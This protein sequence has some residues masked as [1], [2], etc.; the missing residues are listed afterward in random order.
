MADG[1]HRDYA[2][3]SFKNDFEPLPLEVFTPPAGLEVV[4]SRGHQSHDRVLY[5]TRE[6]SYYDKYSDVFLT[7]EQARS[8]GLP[9]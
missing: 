6:G 7:L 8:F 4:F 1:F 9:V 2:R 5:D 3:R